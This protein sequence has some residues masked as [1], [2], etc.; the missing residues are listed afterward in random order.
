[1]NHPSYPCITHSSTVDIVHELFQS[2]DV[3]RHPVVAKV[4][5]AYESHEQKL[6]RQKKLKEN[7]ASSSK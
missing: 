2:K 4:V 7:Q 6:N 3:V 5:D 1:M